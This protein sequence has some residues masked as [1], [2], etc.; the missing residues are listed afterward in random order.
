MAQAK[1]ENADQGKADYPQ[2]ALC[3]SAL[4][5]KLLEDAL[6]AASRLGFTGVEVRGREPHVGEVYDHN[7]SRQC[8][9]LCEERRL[10][11]AAF[12]SYLRFGATRRAEDGV[13][14]LETLQAAGRDGL[15]DPLTRLAADEVVRSQRSGG[16]ASGMTVAEVIGGLVRTLPC[17]T[18]MKIL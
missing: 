7:R 16:R 6:I 12:G 10:E 2:V 17:Q 13:D 8:K 9:G 15:D 18:Q 5:E 14:L 11:I 4:S 1:V 3:T